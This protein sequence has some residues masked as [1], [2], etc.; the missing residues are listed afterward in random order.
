MMPEIN[1][2]GPPHIPS[3]FV[4]SLAVLDARLA[5]LCC[6]NAGYELVIASKDAR[7]KRDIEGTDFRLP[8]KELARV[9]EESKDLAL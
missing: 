4:A 3:L 1:Y 9:R 8:T 5:A 6:I 2:P 7:R